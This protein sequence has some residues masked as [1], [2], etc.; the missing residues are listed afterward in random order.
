MNEFT[1]EELED[2]YRAISLCDREGYEVGAS[3][4]LPKIK[5]M[6]DSYC[7]HEWGSTI[8]SATHAGLSAHVECR[9]CHAKPNLTR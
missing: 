1:K 8:P 2:I 6:I 5:S 7:E 3:E 9:K 4:M